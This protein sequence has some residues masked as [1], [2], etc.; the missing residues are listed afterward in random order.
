[1]LSRVRMAAWALV[2][3]VRWRKVP[4]GLAAPSLSLPSGLYRHRRHRLVIS[5]RSALCYSELHESSA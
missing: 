5:C 1:M 2:S 3:S 4:A